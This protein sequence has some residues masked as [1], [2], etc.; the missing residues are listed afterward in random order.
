MR[1]S[2]PKVLL[3]AC[4]ALA[5]CANE[6]PRRTYAAA[7]AVRSGLDMMTYGAPAAYRQRPMYGQQQVQGQA[8]EQQA[9]AH[10]RPGHQ[11][12][13]AYVPP[14]YRRPPP[15][16]V[17]AP[18]PP[19]A[20]SHPV[21]DATRYVPPIEQGPYTLDTGDKLRIVVFGQDTLS[22]TYTVDA[23]GQ[24][25]MPLIGAVMA[26]DLTTAALGAAIRSKLA[27]GFI[28]EPSVAVE[29]EVYRPFFVLGEVTYPGQYPF[30]PHM[31]V[32]NAVAI[33]GGFTPRASKDSVTI[34]RKI[35]GVPY[36]F[37]Q[38]LRTPIRPGDVV[39]VGERWF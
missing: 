39:T 30:V 12:M 23:A 32:E 16:Y 25:S 7:P 6:P 22:N 27:S 37:E 15:T 24:I 35:Q 19:P 29:V 13:A 4:T 20:R 1:V 3:V 11:A 14:V 21:R 10:Q 34:T 18:P 17:P 33:A 38:P 36:R 2:R 28:R 26:R 9:P 8:P 31:T 5:G